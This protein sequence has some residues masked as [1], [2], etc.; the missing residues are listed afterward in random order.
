MASGHIACPGRPLLSSAAIRLL[1]RAIS[2]ERRS[3]LTERERRLR[4]PSLRPQVRVD[5]AAEIGR[6]VDGLWAIGGED[7]SQVDHV[8][9]RAIALESTSLRGLTTS[10]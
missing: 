8:L 9:V 5:D 6:L 10:K 4:W 3:E 2:Q 1:L 7:Q